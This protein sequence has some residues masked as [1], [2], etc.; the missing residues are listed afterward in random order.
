MDVIEL[1]PADDIVSICDQLDWVKER[2]VLLVLPNDG[3]VLS[4]QV[5]LARL[6]RRADR[7]RLEVG[8]VTLDP[9]VILLA[10][11]LGFPAFGTASQAERDERLWRR[12]RRRQE[13]A[14]LSPDEIR[15]TFLS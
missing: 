14:G 13:K 12:G 9:Q 7:L 11:A 3:Q 1:L 4:N 5:D 8:L 10:R 15:R 2:R 6:R